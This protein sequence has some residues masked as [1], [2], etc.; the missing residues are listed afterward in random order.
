MVRFGV[1]SLQDGW[2]EIAEAPSNGVPRRVEIEP[3]EEI[4]ATTP[5]GVVDP[6]SDIG[7]LRVLVNPDTSL[8]DGEVL[9]VDLPN[10]RAYYQVVA[11]T[12]KEQQ[13]PDSQCIQSVEVTA[14][15]LG[16]CQPGSCRFGRVC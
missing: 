3:L 16:V 1:T 7:S 13:A 10:N 4:A 5:A 2:G 11:A 6:G 9:A 8:V 14:S 12:L 15:Q